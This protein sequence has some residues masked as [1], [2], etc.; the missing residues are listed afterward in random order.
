MCVW[1]YSILSY[2]ITELREKGFQLLESFGSKN[3]QKFG[4]NDA[5]HFRLLQKLAIKLKEGNFQDQSELK[6]SG[7]GAA[8]CQLSESTLGTKVGKQKLLSCCILAK[9][10]VGIGLVQQ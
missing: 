1:A 10:F 3:K 8:A 4:R 6:E 7:K 9:T 2:N 5:H